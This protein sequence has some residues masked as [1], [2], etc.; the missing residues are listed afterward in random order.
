M[1][2]TLYILSVFVLSTMLEGCLSVLQVSERYCDDGYLYYYAVPNKASAAYKSDK[3]IYIHCPVIPYRIKHTLAKVAITPSYF[4]GF[5][6]IEVNDII[7][8]TSIWLSYKNDIKPIRPSDFVVVSPVE[9]ELENMEVISIP[10]YIKNYQCWHSYDGE[11]EYMIPLMPL[12]E[13]KNRNPVCIKYMSPLLHYCI[14]WP[15]SIIMTVSGSFWYIP[16][17]K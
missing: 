16:L 9:F 7:T 12:V 15:I 10:F 2:K 5:Q 4:G 17:A 8:S 13:T 14:D 1:R 3:A 6:H 11:P